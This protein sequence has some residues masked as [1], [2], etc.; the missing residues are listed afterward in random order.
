MEKNK[1]KQKKKVIRRDREESMNR[2]L[3]SIKNIKNR[4]IEE[5]KKKQ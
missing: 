4:G 1:E 3:Y 2:Y 5:K